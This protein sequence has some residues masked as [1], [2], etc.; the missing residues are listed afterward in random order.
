MYRTIFEY[1]ELTNDNSG[2][3]FYHFPS[4]NR[5]FCALSG[6][7]RREIDGKKKWKEFVSPE[8]IDKLTN[9]LQEHKKEGI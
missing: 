4:A 2:E 1:A 3:R 8:D 5:K 9:Y 6:Y 7:R